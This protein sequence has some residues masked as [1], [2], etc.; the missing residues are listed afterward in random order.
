MPETLPTCN[1][2]VS[3]APDTNTDCTI[4]LAVSVRVKLK[5]LVSTPLTGSE[6]VT[7][8]RRLLALLGEASTRV[9]DVTVSGGNTVSE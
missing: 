9:M 1:V 7:W 4:P 5:S 8:K 3:P 2:Y 6:K